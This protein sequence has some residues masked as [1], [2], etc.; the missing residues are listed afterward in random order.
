MLCEFHFS[1]SSIHVDVV[2]SFLYWL[3]M[4][5]FIVY[6]HSYLLCTYTVWYF[7]SRKLYVEFR[8]G[9]FFTLSSISYQALFDLRKLSRL[10]LES[11]HSSPVQGH[12]LVI[13]LL[14]SKQSWF[15]YIYSM[16]FSS[17]V[18]RKL[19]YL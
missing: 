18:E 19:S 10:C 2:A 16:H 14:Y 6:V 3:T 17:G 15:I 13:V 12:V 11:F 8:Y 1:G 9:C 4:L 5:Y 7:C